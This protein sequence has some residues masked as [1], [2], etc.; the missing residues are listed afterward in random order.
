MS[1]FGIVVRELSKSFGPARVLDQVSFQLPSASFGVV[2]GENGAGKTTLLRILATTLLADAGN[3][4]I[5]GCDV[6]RQA[7][8]ARARAS[9]LLADDRTWYWRLT[10]RQNLEFFTSL[11]PQGKQTRRKDIDNA[12]QHVGLTAV[13]DRPVATY[14]SGMKLKLAIAR[15][16]TADARVLLMDEPTR[17]LDSAATSAFVDTLL[18]LKMT[19]HMT[20]LASTHNI[21]EV[22]DVADH[23]FLMQD[24]AVRPVV[25]DRPR[26]GL[27]GSAPQ[28]AARA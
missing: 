19:Q 2:L 9:L 4:W 21:A 25:L 8:E 27:I 13:G 14:S 24:G 5:D 16:L 12:L 7:R 28:P 15:C 22:A 23:A 17:S 6:V 26:T 11:R 10:G 18:G 20:I 3:A 1:E